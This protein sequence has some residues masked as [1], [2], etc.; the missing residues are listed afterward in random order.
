MADFVKSP[1]VDGYLNGVTHWREEMEKLREIA[2]NCGLDEELKWGKPCYMYEGGNVAIIGPFK[3]YCALMFVNGAL[4]KDP[5]HILFQQTEHVQA[6]RIV[7]I[8]SVEEV[9][10]L[11]PVLKAYLMEAIEVE[12]AGL[13]VD[14]SHRTD[15]QM[16][17]ELKAK[18]QK[19]P[20]LKAAF[21]ALSPGRQ[22]KYLLYFSQ[23][24]QSETREA[25]IEKYEGQIA[26]G[27]GMDD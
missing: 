27:K 13:K 19:N 1:L 21:D 8:T 22:R 14:T 26:D 6:G 4:L 10:R 2:L 17:E 25:R 11:A 9:E 7:K 16:P 5:E 23:A 24:K 12:K 20:V 18:F 3:D 15:I